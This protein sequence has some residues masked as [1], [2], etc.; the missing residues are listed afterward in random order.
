MARS[1]NY[2]FTDFELLNIE[3]IYNNNL[4]DIRYIC[5][6]IEICPKTKRTHQQGWVQFNTPKGF[7]RCKKLLGSDTIH[8]ESCMGS[9][10]SNE[11]YCKKDNKFIKFGKFITQGHRTDLDQ[12]KT[13]IEQN[14]GM[15]KIASKHFKNFCRYYSAFYKYR[16][17]H[18]K[19][20]TSPFR[21][22]KV[23]LIC[24]PTGS[25]KT[26]YAMKK[27]PF[28][29]QGDNLQWWDGY[30]GEETI[31]ID[32]YNNDVPITKMLSYLDGYQLRL[33][34]KGGFTYAN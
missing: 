6:G 8:I 4:K 13:E 29:I 26:R 21:K 12:I 2:C 5:R 27:K 16:Q 23:V 19:D 31:L 34:I 32:E 25:G 3:T 1:R 22:V 7:A 30:E 17:L 20:A 28:K 18:L 14:V 24:G 11:K 10:Y 15:R 33:P 9:T